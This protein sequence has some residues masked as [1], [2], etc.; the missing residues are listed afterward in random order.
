LPERPLWENFL[1][2][3]ERKK[4]FVRAGFIRKQEI[5]RFSEE[6]ISAN[7]IAAR[8]PLQIL[9]GLSG[10]NRQKVAL[11]RVLGG[12][13]LLA[14]L[15][16]PCRGL[17]LR[18]AAAVHDRMLE[19]GGSGGASFILISYDFDELISVCDRIAVIYRGELIGTDRSEHLSR[20]ILG[21]WA[22]GVKNKD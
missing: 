6:Q 8:G 1:L 4:E 17:D 21:R 13:P 19:L 15:E 11:A 20:E 5:I 10:G 16:Q 14:V 3:L 9:S 12:S 18:A 7:D 2:G 22:A